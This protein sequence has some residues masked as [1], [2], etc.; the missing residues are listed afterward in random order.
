VGQPG[1]GRIHAKTGYIRG[2]RTLSGYVN[3]RG[4]E[5][6]AFSFLYNGGNTGGARNVQHQLGNLLAEFSR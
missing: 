5:T 6:I 1:A 2:V 3:A 4:G